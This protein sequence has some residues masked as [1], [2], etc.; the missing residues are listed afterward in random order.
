ML[1]ASENS[2]L[3]L[4]LAI[5][6]LTEYSMKHWLESHTALLKAPRAAYALFRGTHFLLNL[7][8]VA[9]LFGI[10]RQ[11]AAVVVA[12]VATVELIALLE[13]PIAGLERIVGRTLGIRLRWL[14]LLPFAGIVGVVGFAEA[15]GLYGEGRTL[16]PWVAQA[17][18]DPAAGYLFAFVLLAA[19]ANHIVRC[20]I[21]KATDRF[22]VDELFQ[23]PAAIGTPT[24]PASLPGL[25]AAAG[26]VLRTE[27]AA[28]VEAQAA[29]AAAAADVHG[30][31]A[32]PDATTLRAGRTIGILERWIVLLLTVIGQFGLI[33]LVI[34]AKS[35]ARFRRLE[36]DPEFAEY[37]LLGTLY[38][39]LMALLAG[40]ALTH[41]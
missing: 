2:S 28:T 12:F 17:L 10:D 27:T 41:V 34:T 8:L 15:A 38:S 26:E 20:L 30:R 32:H 13:V 35:I 9:L 40:V 6:L 39:I 23:V 25:G 29:N 33:G 7:A 18:P 1:P 24:E 5:F 16:A 31:T 37:Y 4:M 21:D 11:T 36:H 14:Q 3:W 19:P 22:L